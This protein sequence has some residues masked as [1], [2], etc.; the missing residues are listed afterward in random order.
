MPVPTRQDTHNV[1]V[2]VDGRQIGLFDTKSGGELDTEE[3]LYNPGGMLGQV[4]IGGAPTIGNVTIERYYDALRDHP[5]MAWLG[6]R[7]GYGRVSI[8]ITPRDPQGVVRGDPLV[9]AGTLKTVTPPEL[10]STGNDMATWSMEVTCDSFTG[11][12]A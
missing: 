9:Y 1:T 12:T 6:N 5:L 2:S 7:R 8:G 4:S 11:P 10:D 3:N